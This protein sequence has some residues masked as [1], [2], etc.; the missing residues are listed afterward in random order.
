MRLMWFPN[1]LVIPETGRGMPSMSIP[2]ST[3][4]VLVEGHP[5]PRRRKGR[6]LFEIDAADQIAQRVDRLMEISDL[7]QPGGHQA[8]YFSIRVDVKTLMPIDVRSASEFIC[9]RSPR[10]YL[11]R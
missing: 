10:P 9:T 7:D 1:D 3:R 5:I 8:G 2:A 4:H 11:G 6:E